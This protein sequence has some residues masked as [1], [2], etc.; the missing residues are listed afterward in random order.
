L[1]IGQP[2][3]AE[4][5]ARL[6]RRACDPE[7]DPRHA[8][9]DVAAEL[10]PLADSA[11]G[12]PA[13]LASELRELISEVRSVQPAFPSRRATSPLFDRAGLGRLG[14]ARAERI[15]QRLVALARAVEKVR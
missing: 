15:V 12:L 9:L 14:Y 3:L 8:V 11:E 6:A 5:L 10:L 1:D 4:M 2:T 13:H 7:Y